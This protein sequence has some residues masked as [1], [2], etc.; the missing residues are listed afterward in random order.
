VKRPPDPQAGRPQ[1]VGDL[2]SRFLQ[3][4]GLSARV[5]AASILTE[6]SD[7]VGP[8]IAAVTRAQRLSDE[9]LFVGVATSAWMMELNLMRAELLRRVNAGK[10]EGR[11]R[12]IVFVM[13]EAS[14]AVGRQS[15]VSGRRPIGDSPTDD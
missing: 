10:R 7:L 2:V 6:W 14:S 5:E 15:S 13:D 8:Q 11:I 9:T 12:Q 1:L 3:R 4:A